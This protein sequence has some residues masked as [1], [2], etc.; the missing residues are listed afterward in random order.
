MP[1]AADDM[2]WDADAYAARHALLVEAAALGATERAAFLAERCGGDATLRSDVEAMLRVHDGS[3]A[4]E[5][6][7]AL[8]DVAARAADALRAD[9]SPPSQL[10][11]WTLLE[12]IAEG[13][14][15]VVYK[16]RQERPERLAAIKFLRP[17][18]ASERAVRR[19][20]LEAEVLAQFDHPGIAKVYAMGVVEDDGRARPYF[21]MEFV[22]GKPIDRYADDAALDVDARIDLLCDVCSA[23]DHAHRRGVIHRDLKPGNILVTSEGHVKVLD[24]G[25]ARVARSPDA[26]ASLH[27]T[28]GGL[29]GTLSYMGPEQIVGDQ[30]STSTDVYALGV[31]LYQLLTGRLPLDLAGVPLARAAE[32]LQ[33]ETPPLV[34]SV[35]ARLRGD[36][37]VVVATALA[38]DPARRYPSAA[39]LADDL[40]HVQRRE[41]IRAR[42]PR[43]LYLLGRFMARHRA[44]VSVAS[45]LLAAL[46]G[47]LVLAMQSAS[48]ER[49]ARAQADHVSEA[50]RK[51]SY[52]AALA[53]ALLGAEMGYTSQVREALEEA[54]LELRRWEWDLLA[55]DVDESARVLGADQE[56]IT[57]GVNHGV[58]AFFVPIR[59]ENGAFLPGVGGDVLELQAT[60]TLEG[61]TRAGLRLRA[62]AD[63]DG[64]MPIEFDGRTLR[65]NETAVDLPESPQVRLHVFLDKSV[66]EVFVNDGAHVITQVIYPNSEDRQIWAYAENGAAGFTDVRVWELS[67]IW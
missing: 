12:R 36:L 24:F 19:L 52:R 35:D 38:K 5:T 16:A 67:S 31:V 65:V 53:S 30:V 49:R 15:G 32:R 47:S 56:L 2:P 37:E 18:L 23:V 62:A 27:L 45:L 39:A 8:R 55:A 13:G 17:E 6:A 48:R 43:A 50:A 58:H 20:E 25:V 46:L 44:A 66:V 14:M 63:G 1:A 60:L 3:A 9:H 54:P 11:S 29:L 61:A 10:G 33:H 41:P 34:G 51:S 21:A 59:D 26:T 28:T 40:R 4:H 7:D 64:G 42:S 57:Q 22:E